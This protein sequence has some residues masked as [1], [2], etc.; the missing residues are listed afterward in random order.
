M[1]DF[2]ELFNVKINQILKLP[3]RLKILSRKKKKRTEIYT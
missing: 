2:K 3:S 1:I